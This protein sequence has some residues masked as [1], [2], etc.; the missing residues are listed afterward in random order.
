MKSR[1][2]AG[3]LG[4]SLWLAGCGLAD[5][6]KPPTRTPR[7][8]ITATIA[9]QSTGLAATE[10]PPPLATETPSPSLAQDTASPDAGPATAAP[11]P[12]ATRRPFVFQPTAIQPLT[13]TNI[14]IVLVE[15][16]PIRDNGAI[17]SLQIVYTGGRGPYTIYHDDTLQPENPFKVLTVCHGTLNHTVRLISADQQVVTKQYFLWP[18]ECP[19]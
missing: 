11:R 13:I 7:P 19:P 9:S 14:L 16:D 1:F 6:P 4:L 3:V 10:T 15:R 5:T 17:A 8:T 18:V 12:T 2:I